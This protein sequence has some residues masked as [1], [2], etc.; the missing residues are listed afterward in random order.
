MAPICITGIVTIESTKTERDS[1]EFALGY[2][3][4]SRADQEMAA[5]RQSS[6]T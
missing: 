5:S 2:D 6:G 3:G 4:R 1:T